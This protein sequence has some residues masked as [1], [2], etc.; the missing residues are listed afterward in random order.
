[1]TV[2]IL[3]VSDNHGYPQPVVSLKKQYA[4]YDLFIHLGD[5][6]IDEKDLAGWIVVCGNNDPYFYDP[7]PFPCEKII[8]L[9]GHRILLEHGHLDHIYTGHYQQMVAHALKEQCDT[10][11]FGHTHVYADTSLNGVRLLNPGSL[12]FP[13][14]GSVGTYMT[15][16]I[17]SGGINAEKH[18]WKSGKGSRPDDFF[19]R[20]RAFLDGNKVSKNDAQK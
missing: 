19:E 13:R 8:T 11:L 6:C 5:A 1:M 10:V 18:F 15:I 12:V 2:R 3:A 14:D 7:L 20:L 9:E 4:D 17:S 16:E